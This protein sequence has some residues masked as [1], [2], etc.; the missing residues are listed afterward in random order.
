LLALLDG[1]LFV[2]FAIIGG[3]ALTGG[4]LWLCGE[5]LERKGALA[6]ETKDAALAKQEKRIKLE[7]KREVLSP[8]SP[9]TSFETRCRRRP[10]A[11]TVVLR[12]KS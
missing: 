1:H 2:F 7:R 6:K 11:P 3:V 4:M 8:I 10:T 12:Y 9:G 5:L